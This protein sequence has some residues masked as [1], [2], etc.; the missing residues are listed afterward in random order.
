MTKVLE[1]VHMLT[2]ERLKKDTGMY[3]RK[4]ASHYD[5]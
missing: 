5:V 3:V 4:M 1:G 2:T